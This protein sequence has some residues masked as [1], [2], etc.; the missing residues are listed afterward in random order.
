MPSH[1]AANSMGTSSGLAYRQARVASH[2]R[3]LYKHPL[4][5][6]CCTLFQN[7]SI[8]PSFP[9]LSFP[10]RLSLVGMS[11]SAHHKFTHFSHQHRAN[12]W[13]IPSGKRNPLQ[14]SSR[15]RWKDRRILWER[16]RLPRRN[17]GLRHARSSKFLRQYWPCLCLARSPDTSVFVS[18]SVI[19]RA[20]K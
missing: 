12:S 7:I 18:L 4:L 20:S 5:Y 6:C 16:R 17:W 3:P 13:T 8:L 19:K 10:F 15:V 1:V 2:R 14:C 11:T 9:F